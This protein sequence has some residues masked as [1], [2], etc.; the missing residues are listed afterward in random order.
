MHEGV[1]GNDTCYLVALR[2]EFLPEN[3]LEFVKSLTR[4]GRD[5]HHL[6]IIRQCLFQ[7]LDKLIVK[8]ITL[9]DGKHTMLLEHLWI[10]LLKLIEQELILLLYVV[11][12][13]GHH[14]EQQG[15]AL[16]MAK[17]TKT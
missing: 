16:N 5:K 11:S 3:I 15:V 12:I 7:H 9:C 1:S 13:T 17:E 2:V 14:E 4:N 8:K 10:E 6:K